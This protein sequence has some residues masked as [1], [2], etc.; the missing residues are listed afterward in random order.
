MAGEI[1]IIVIVVKITLVAIINLMGSLII[2]MKISHE[3]NIVGNT[4]T[5]NAE[6][7]RDSYST[8]NNSDEN[9]YNI[10]YD[11]FQ[12]LIVVTKT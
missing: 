2:L 12:G 7:H 3:N 11:N 9:N 5:D 8:R 4:G 6:I 1:E 10:H